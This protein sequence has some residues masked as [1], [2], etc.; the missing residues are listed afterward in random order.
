MPT[1]C[2]P[3]RPDLAHLKHQAADLLKGHRARNIQVL[4]RLRE[5]HPRL[6]GMSDREVAGAPLTLSDAYLATAREYGFPSWPKLKDFVEN[7]SADVLSLPAHE[8]VSDPEFRRAIELLDA[9]DAA[10]LRTHLQEHPDVVR[11]RATLYGGNYFQTPTLLEFVAENPTRHG[12]LPSNI[13]DVARVILEAG[14]ARDR[15][16]MNSALDL[17]ASSAVARTSGVQNELIDILCAFGADPDAA[18]LSA[19]LYG[20]FDAAKRLLERGASLNLLAASAL[21]LTADVERLARGAGDDDRRIALALAAQ[22]GRTACV[23]ALL[24]NGV[25]P[26][27][28]T[29]VRGHSHATALHQAALAGS[30]EIVDLLL[31]YGAQAGVRDILYGGTPAG[32]AA[33]NGFTGLAARLRALE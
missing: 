12:R 13:A 17:S 24:E 11:R 1:R 22:H 18:V 27:G 32:W 29:P 21:G 9:G 10:G 33:H 30:D 16:A 26:N 6:R 19:L 23:R 5:F 28:F 2:L 7:G 8:R 3:P 20:E 31:E 15:A 4:H 14:G 25:D